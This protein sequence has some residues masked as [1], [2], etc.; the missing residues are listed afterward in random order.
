MARLLIRMSEY[1]AAESL[2]QTI[3]ERAE[4]AGETMSILHVAIQLADSRL[5]QGMPGEA[6]E[7]LDNAG[8]GVG[9]ETLRPTVA[10]VRGRA[11]AFLGMHEQAL[12]EIEAGLEQARKQGLLYDQ[13]ILLADKNELID[14]S[15]GVP[16][17]VEKQEEDRLFGELDVRREPV[18]PVQPT[19]T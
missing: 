19:L 16:D 15:G 13:A 7:I 6:L 17:R 1:Q 12:R 2:L 8:D 18:L 4:A 3:R 10:H 5:R 14:E 11:L 9:M